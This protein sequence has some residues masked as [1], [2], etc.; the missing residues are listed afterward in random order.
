M[1]V[2]GKLASMNDSRQIS[3]PGGAGLN[4]LGALWNSLYQGESWSTSGVR[5]GVSR[6]VLICFYLL[7]WGEDLGCISLD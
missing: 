2:T 5:P 4:K 7:Y 6:N 3:S 1:M